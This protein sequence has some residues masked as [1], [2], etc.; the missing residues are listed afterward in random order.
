MV[1]LATLYLA[2]TAFTGDVQDTAVTR[3]PVII[4]THAHLIRNRRGDATST[5]SQALRAM[6]EFKVETTI[7][8][9]PP[10][11]S[12]H[13]GTYGRRE[14]ESVIREHPGRFALVAGGE[15]LNPVIHDVAPEKVTR[16][17]VQRFQKEA[18]LI[19][20]SAAVGFGELTAEHFSSGRGSHPHEATRPDHPLFLVPCSGA[21]RPEWRAW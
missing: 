21:S 9:P 5:A 7:L 8:L 16:E 2:T 10:F 1:A 11:S 3:Q 18:L 13:R 17:H 4:D 15:S 14:L 12:N 20:A 6:D 19:V